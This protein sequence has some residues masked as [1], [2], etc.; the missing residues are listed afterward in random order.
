MKVPYSRGRSGSGAGIP[1]LIAIILVAAIITL[2]PGCSQ[3]KS[4]RR[5]NL[6]PF[7]ENMI[8]IAGDIQYGLA[9]QEVIYLRNH[10]NI[11]EVDNLNIYLGKMR[12]VMRGSIAY[13]IEIV[14]L[15]NSTLSGSEQCDALA[16]YLDGLLR[17]VLESPAP[18][19]HFSIAKLDTILDNARQQTKLLDALGT[20]QPIVNE[21]ART[22]SEI[23][24][25]TNIA[26][27]EATDAI[28]E[29]LLKNNE[30]LLKGI[31]TMREY[32]LHTVMSIEYIARY[33][34]GEK[35]ALDTLFAMQPSL[36][37]VVSSTTR[38]SAED[39]R[40]IEDRLLYLL[41]SMHDVREQMMPDLELYWKQQRELDGLIKT[42]KA[43]LRKAHVA[44]IAW[45]R[46]HQRLAAGMTDP[47]KIDVL[48]LAGKA[49]GAASRAREDCRDLSACSRAFSAQFLRSAA[50]LLVRAS[51]HTNRIQRPQYFPGA[52]RSVHV[53]LLPAGHG[54]RS[55]GFPSRT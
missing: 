32:Q 24:D 2:M 17:P 42:Y 8:A 5:M 43:A 45:S 11:P 12:A 4:S 20:T 52:L 19:L 29:T 38:P 49:A 3:F 36:K 6:N 28:R 22:T 39:M 44:I 48:G 30:I 47:A 27:D 55:T 54:S 23:I 53:P 33:R 10:I 31:R 25:D 14:T 46:A 51:D 50:V 40:A 21:I 15:S 7:A 34:R 13:S 37:E 35:A 41:K 18:P 9:Q 1:C 26:M 16:D